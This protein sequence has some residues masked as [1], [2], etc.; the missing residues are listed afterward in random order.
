M[1][2]KQKV[3]KTKLLSKSKKIQTKKVNRQQNGGVLL[4]VIKK[5]DSN[6]PETEF[7]IDSLFNFFNIKNDNGIRDYLKYA[8]HDAVGLYPLLNWKNISSTYSYNN[9]NS[10]I[11]NASNNNMQKSHNKNN[12]TKEKFAVGSEVKP[13]N[14]KITTRENPSYYYNGTFTKT[15]D[16]EKNKVTFICEV[17]HNVTDGNI[18]VLFKWGKRYD[19]TKPE[20]SIV[21]DN[22]YNFIK[23]RI[24]I[25]G[26]SNTNILLFGFSMGGNIAQHIALRFMDDTSIDG[27]RMKD[28]IYVISFG[29][30]GT[31]TEKTIDTFNDT[32]TGRFISIAISEDIERVPKVD[33]ELKSSLNLQNNSMHNKI[34]TYILR[35]NNETKSIKSLIIN[36]NAS[37]DKDYKPMYIKGRFFD[38]KTLNAIYFNKDKISHLHDFTRYRKYIDMLVNDEQQS[39]IN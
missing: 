27:N 13:N 2:L 25:G 6:I 20:C 22:M 12:K 35:D 28:N 29:I 9:S 36:M 17:F 32:I 37:F 23:T 11:K 33:T 39:I 15:I 19:L 21:L 3:L 5:G 16:I 4:N 1:V 26:Y 24:I 14:I 18:L 30:G 34:N 8:I 31:M 38:Y 7:N 10:I